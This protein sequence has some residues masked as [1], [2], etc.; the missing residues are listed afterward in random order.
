[1]DRGAYAAVHP[2]Q[3]LANEALAFRVTPLGDVKPTIV[4]GRE[5]EIYA[6]AL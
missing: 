5:V 3:R 4:F 6:P 2:A 1:V